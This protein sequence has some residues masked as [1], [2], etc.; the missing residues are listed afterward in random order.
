M[1]K[2][3]S[4]FILS[5]IV[6]FLN[7]VPVFAEGTTDNGSIIYNTNTVTT[8]ETSQSTSQYSPVK[9]TASADLPN[10]TI[11]QASSWIDRKGFEIIRFLQKIAQPFAIIIFIISAGMLLV[12]AISG[13]D[14]ASKG[15][16]GMVVAIIMYAVVLYAPEL[17]QMGLNWLRS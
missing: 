9:D 15:I 13:N 5:F 4:L 16:W 2:I 1:K 8:N 10:V 11:E 12:G 3:M 17:V 7:I 6:V 14:W